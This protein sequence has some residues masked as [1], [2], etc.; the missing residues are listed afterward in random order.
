VSRMRSEL[1]VVGA[2]G[3]LVSAYM[4]FY[5]YFQGGYR[6]ISPSSFAGLDIS[7]SFLLNAIAGLVIAEA[8]LLSLKFPRLVFPAAAL[9]VLFALGAIGAYIITRTTGL[10]GFNENSWS[11][12]AVISKFAEA[13]AVLALV[14]VVLSARPAAPVP[15]SYNSK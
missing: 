14:P 2:A 12:E 4:H 6:S 13:I 15:V 3:V 9:G 11:T 10:L 1:I 5:L 7:R 8:L